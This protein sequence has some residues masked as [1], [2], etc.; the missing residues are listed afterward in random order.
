MNGDIKN[1][2]KTMGNIE[3]VYTQ[4]YNNVH[5]VV[6]YVRI[7]TEMITSLTYSDNA[8]TAFTCCL[9]R[10]MSGQYKWSVSQSSSTSQLTV[11]FI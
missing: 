8:W 7:K 11:P 5:R 2:H 4:N 6:L 3:Q 9:S 10:R 1:A